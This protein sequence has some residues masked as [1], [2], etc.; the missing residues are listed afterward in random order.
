[1][2][3]TWT[4][5]RPPEAAGLCAQ[6]AWV[7]TA[8]SRLTQCEAC[9]L[10]A[11]ARAPRFDYD[12][13]YFTVDGD[14]GYDFDTDYARDADAERFRREL[15]RLDRRGPRGTLLDIGCATGS[16]LCA[17]RDRG[18]TVTG[19]EVAEYARTQAAAR[20]GGLVVASCDELPA[21]TTF[22]VVTLHHVLEHIDD[23]VAFLRDAVAPRVG[24]R[25]VLETPNFQSLASRVHGS[26][27]RDLRL[28]QHVSHFTPRTL[29][30]VV[31][32]AG[33][34]VDRVYTLWEALWSLRATRE[35]GLLV[36]NGALGRDRRWEAAAGGDG[37]VAATKMT[38]YRRP[39]GARRAFTTVS[40]A[41]CAPIVAGLETMGLGVRLV[42]EAMPRTAR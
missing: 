16:Y 28:E 40:R 35:L 32:A 7:E 2:L 29:A 23:P 19:V 36:L 10:V 8:G 27:W 30:A 11:T 9:G 26:R 22:D 24:R 14:G 31:E 33:L 6:H 42:V 25:L 12:R 13:G 1:V 4:L 34:R 20:S 3:E 37:E 15:D 38:E 17:A 41:A 21:G 39:T 5:T 18:W